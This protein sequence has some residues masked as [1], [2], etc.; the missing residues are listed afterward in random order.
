MQKEYKYQKTGGFTVPVLRLWCLDICPVLLGP[1]LVF[2][3]I[4][5]DFLTRI[6]VCFNVCVW[7]YVLDDLMGLMRGEG[8]ARL[9]NTS[10]GRRWGRKSKVCAQGALLCHNENQAFQYHKNTVQRGIGK[11]AQGKK[12]TC[13]P[14][15][16]IALPVYPFP[17]PFIRALN[18]HC[19]YF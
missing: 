6:Y 16:L 11:K 10:V 18:F 15:S 12:N 8:Y 17:I 14:R 4:V 1:S 7:Y 5:I 3:A 9:G 19:R 13:I 2:N